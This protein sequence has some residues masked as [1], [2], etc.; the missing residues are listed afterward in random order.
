M[1]RFCKEYHIDEVL[2]SLYQLRIYFPF[3]RTPALVS[4]GCVTWGWQDPPSF[5]K[6]KADQCRKSGGMTGGQP[7]SPIS[8]KQA[9][10]LSVKG[11]SSFAGSS[12]NSTLEKVHPI[13]RL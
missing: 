2:F 9:I 11:Q 13:T 4:G 10:G 8:S 12:N 3:Q 7:W 1:S 6:M 5:N